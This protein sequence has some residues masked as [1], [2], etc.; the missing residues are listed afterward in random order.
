MGLTD[1]PDWRGVAK[2]FRRTDVIKV[3]AN[4]KMETR[5]VPIPLDHGILSELVAVPCRKNEIA[6]EMFQKLSQFVFIGFGP[7]IEIVHNQP[8]P[9]FRVT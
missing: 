2:V 1:S 8:A 5:V 3:F 6:G 7:P 4:Q 9:G